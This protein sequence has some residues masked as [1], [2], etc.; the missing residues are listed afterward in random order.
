LEGFT[1]LLV[2]A[3]ESCRR[4]GVAHPRARPWWSRLRFRPCSAEV[5]GTMGLLNLAI[6]LRKGMTP[7]ELGHGLGVDAKNSILAADLHNH[8][9]R[10]LIFDI[11]ALIDPLLY[12]ENGVIAV[13]LNVQLLELEEGLQLHE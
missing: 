1:A 10:M 3:T 4:A 12:G 8:R 9:M 2:D 13:E 6:R 7:P 11:G 5:I